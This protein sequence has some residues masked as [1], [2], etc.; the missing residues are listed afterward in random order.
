MPQLPKKAGFSIPWNVRQRCFEK[1]YLQFKRINATRAG[2][3]LVGEAIKKEEEMVQDCFDRSIYMN[4]IA[5][6]L[7]ALGKEQPYDPVKI[8]AA[9]KAKQ[10]S[11]PQGATSLSL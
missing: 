5:N 9:E 10:D 11:L 4:K 2:Y 7:T 8:A 1:L 3:D 6:L